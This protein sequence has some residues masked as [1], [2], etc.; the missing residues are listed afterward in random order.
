MGSLTRN[1][2]GALAHRCRWPTTK[3]S[4]QLVTLIRAQCVGPGHQGWNAG[5]LAYR[6]VLV[7]LRFTVSL[8]WHTPSRVVIADRA[9]GELLGAHL[10]GAD[11]AELLPELTLA[12]RWDLTETRS[13]PHG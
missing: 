9:H 5:S 10:V 8:A 6:T 1:V 3:L 13:D 12:Q 11:V 2:A 4:R 7:E